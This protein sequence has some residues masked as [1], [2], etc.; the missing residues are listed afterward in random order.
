M[1]A[2][3]AAPHARTPRPA[4]TPHPVRTPP[5]PYAAGPYTWPPAPPG[6]A[7]TGRPGAPAP[8]KARR[9]LAVVAALALVLA[10]AGV[11]AGVAMAVHNG[12]STRTF[13]A[14]GN[15]LPS[16]GSNNNGSSNNSGGFTIPNNGGL[17]IPGFGNGNNNGNSNRAVPATATAAPD[18]STST[19]SRP[20]STP[21]SSTSTRR[22]QQGR[23]AGTGMLISSTGEILTNNHV[24]ADATSIKVTIGGIGATHD[25]KV[26]GYDVT[27]DVALIQITDKVVE[28]SDRRVR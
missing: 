2:H 20:R 4:R 16:N 24:I 19:R 23:A 8:S 6:G 22:S 7:R 21:R 9:G 5:G 10:S 26:V 25:A 15:T 17:T 18:R 3:P 11:G 27:E 12:D 13:S 14:N 1:A 28:S